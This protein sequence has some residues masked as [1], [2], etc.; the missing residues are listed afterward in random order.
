MSSPPNLS[1]S[2]EQQEILRARGNIVVVAGAGTGKTETLTQRVLHLLETSEDSAGGALALHEFIALTFTDKAAGEMRQRIYQSLLRKLIAAR[3]ETERAR[4]RMLC[5]G[6]AETNRVGTFDAFNHRLLAAYPEYQV[7]PSHFT[8]MTPYDE[9]ELTVQLV[10]AFWQWIENLSADDP[11]REDAFYLLDFFNRK[12][13]TQLVGELAREET[14]HLNAL[15]APISE[16]DFEK[17]LETIAAAAALRME[18]RAER[19]LQQLWRDWEKSLR[20]NFELPPALQAILLDEEEIQTRF[21]EIFTA[22]TTFRK[23]WIAPEWKEQCAEIEARALKHLKAWREAKQ[24]L[25]THLLSLRETKATLEF[26]WRARCVLGAAARLALWWSTQRAELCNREGWLDF[27][28]AHRAALALLENHPEVA[29]RLRSGSRFLMVDEF[30]DTNFSQWRLVNAIRA[31]DNVMLIG[32]GKQSIYGFRGGDI[33]VFDEVRALHLDEYAMHSLSVSQRATPNLTTFF[34]ALFREILP[35]DDAG[36]EAWE[37]PF[38]ELHSAREAARESGVTV[39]R[40]E[41][42]T[43]CETQSKKL[44]DDN[45]DNSQQSPNF[46]SSNSKDLFYADDESVWPLIA[47]SQSDAEALAETTALFLRE[48]QED[49]D[50]IKLRRENHELLQPK[51]E[52]VARKIASDEPG[53]IGVLFRT[54]DRKAMFE[55]ALRH[56]GVRYASVKGVGFYQSQPVYDA[57][58]ILRFLFDAHDS[59]A[60]TGVLRSPFV[61]ASDLALLEL[62]RVQTALKCESLWAALEARCAQSPHAEYSLSEADEQALRGACRRMQSWRKL[63]RVKLLSAVLETIWNETEIA[64]TQALQSDGVQWRQNWHKVLD[65]ARGREEQGRGSA[66]ALAEYFMAQASDEEKEADAELPEGGSIQLMTVFAAKGLGFDMTIVAQMD[67]TVRLDTPLW[68][69][70]ALENRDEIF[71]AL[72][73]EDTESNAK[74]PLLWTILEDED[75]ARKQAEFARLFYVACTRARDFLVLAMPSESKNARWAEM[76]NPFLSDKA[77][78]ALQ[79]LHVRAQE[80]EGAVLNFSAGEIALQKSR[81][82]PE[83]NL[84]LLQL[85]SPELGKEASVTQLL[86]FEQNHSPGARGSTPAKANSSLDKMRQLAHDPR[87]HGEVFHLLLK[88]ILEKKASGEFQADETLVARFCRMKSLSVARVPV[89]MR[90]ISGALGWLESQNLDLTRAR[91]EVGFS[92]PTE[93]VRGALA[94]I[95]EKTQWLNGVM[96]LIIPS[97]TGWNIIDFKTHSGSAADKAFGKSRGYDEQVSLYCRAAE[98]SGLDVEGGWIVFLDEAGSAEAFRV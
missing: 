86:N 12:A 46:D 96:D 38:Q 15:A 68:R 19:K 83:I 50:T 21:A 24:Q 41:C 36:R 8:P 69:K 42:E 92:I 98:Y 14:S 22:T 53:V 49:A 58:N 84:A 55:N 48:I 28:D 34:N 27:P 4:W 6:F 79:E 33:T 2:F 74:K 60:F 87:L 25:E 29:A 47:R 44:H 65:I 30:Q 35:A 89:L 51:F 95:S 73:L 78:I 37:A 90:Q 91:S 10:R 11:L 81:R 39:L 97:D 75:R 66:R 80:R 18:R 61:G 3:D 20:A 70:G 94:S 5:A 26:D 72:K 93:L 85:L 23:K 71:Y 17:E 13:L 43:Q 76:A 52:S 62:R 63:A 31:R 32:D 9:R 88:V 40:A 77:I 16:A 82:E 54:H 57:I 7:A 59:L 67:G 64:F 45:R 56:R 1:L